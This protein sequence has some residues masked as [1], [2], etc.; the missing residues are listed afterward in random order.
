MRR[1]ELLEQLK[2]M[3]AALDPGMLATI[4]V[5]TVVFNDAA[6]LEDRATFM[7]STSQQFAA[8]VAAEWAPTTVLGAIGKLC[9]PV[10][11]SFAGTSLENF[12][13]ACEAIHAAGLLAQLKSPRS[14]QAAAFVLDGINAHQ[15]DAADI[16]TEAALAFR[17]GLAK[18]GEDYKLDPTTL[19]TVEGGE[20]CERDVYKRCKM[21][22]CGKH[23]QPPVWFVGWQ[24]SLDKAAKLKAETAAAETAAAAAVAAVAASEQQSAALEAGR[25][26]TSA[27]VRAI[28]A[29]DDA[30]EGGGT[31]GHGGSGSS[32]LPAAPAAVPAALAAVPA[33]PA[34]V[35]GAARAFLEGD[36][37]TVAQRGKKT[38]RL[39]AKITKMLTSHAWVEFDASQVGV[40]GTDK[41]ILLASLKFADALPVVASGSLASAERVVEPTADRVVGPAVLIDVEELHRA[42]SAAPIDASMTEGALGGPTS[43]RSGV[44][45]PAAN[46][47]GED[48]E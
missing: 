48:S 35:L 31:A 4:Q 30:S 16:F 20:N 19:V 34:A 29:G 23:L 12:K 43:G 1:L 40:G 14:Q 28:T 8:T 10:T 7:L 41:K 38:P 47:F 2:G 21:F 22:L 6:P 26:L 37:V 25:G 39:L 32:D 11:P 18:G 46:V 42:P 17:I 44:W 15:P 3:S 13:K 33:A 5:A 45:E 36:R 9:L 24:L 27:D